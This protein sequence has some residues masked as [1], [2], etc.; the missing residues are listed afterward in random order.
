MIETTESFRADEL[1][2][3]LADE[4]VADGTIVSKDVEVAFRAVRRHL[5]APGATLEQAYAHDIVVTKKNEHGITISSVSA[6]S[7]QAMMLE[8]ALAR[9]FAN[10]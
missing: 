4:L 7:I 6:P 2:A 3:A 5:F 1:R 9:E 10:S 8:Q